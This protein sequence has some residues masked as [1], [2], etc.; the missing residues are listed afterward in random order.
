M[1]TDDQRHDLLAGVLAAVQGALARL[2][3]HEHRPFVVDLIEELQSNLEDGRFNVG[4][5]EHPPWRRDG[6]PPAE[7]RTWEAVRADARPARLAGGGFVWFP[8]A[9]WF[10]VCPPRGTIPLPLARPGKP[11]PPA[12]G[13]EAEVFGTEAQAIAALDMAIA[14]AGPAE[15]WPA[16]DFFGTQGS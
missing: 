14:T 5:G 11:W 9:T 6:E 2:P 13:E 12:P 10:G 7:L 3:D 16:T 15:D 8:S 4:G 1:N